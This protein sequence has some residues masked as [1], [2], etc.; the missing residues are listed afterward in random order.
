[1]F[2]IHNKLYYVLITCCS[3]PTANFPQDDTDVLKHNLSLRKRHKFYYTIIC[4]ADLR[5]CV[6]YLIH[7]TL[8]CATF[9]LLNSVDIVFHMLILLCISTLPENL[10]DTKSEILFRVYSFDGSFID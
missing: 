7:Y 8:E 2:V 4:M 1:V 3:P 5:T 9:S 6:L 10:C